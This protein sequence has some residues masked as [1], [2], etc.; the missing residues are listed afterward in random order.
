MTRNVNEMMESCYKYTL[1]KFAYYTECQ[2]ATLDGLKMR[3]STSKCELKRQQDICDGMVQVVKSG[4]CDINN[5]DIN[6][7]DITKLPRLKKLLGSGND[8]HDRICLDVRY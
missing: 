8:E 1:E 2:L 7:V 5:V 6:N 4:L 3:K